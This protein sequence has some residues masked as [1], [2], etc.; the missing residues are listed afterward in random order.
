MDMYGYAC[1]L[2]DI[3]G[4]AGMC[5]HMSGHYVDMGVG[6]HLI[7]KYVN[8]GTCEEV[9]RYAEDTVGCGWMLIHLQGFAF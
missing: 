2:V 1:V 4:Y 5:K 9:C 3:G 8:V 7:D 6:R